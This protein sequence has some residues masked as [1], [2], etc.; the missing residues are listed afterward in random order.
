MSVQ[1]GVY[2]TK[3]EWSWKCPRC[4]T[5]A[6]GPAIPGRDAARQQYKDHRKTCSLA[7]AAPIPESEPPAKPSPKPAEEKQVAKTRKPTKKQ[8][9]KRAK[10]KGR[11]RTKGAVALVFKIADSMSDAPRKDVIAAC[12]K[13]GVN[14]HT[15]RTQY[16]RW[17]HS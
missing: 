17:S 12:V 5:E 2:T 3:G 15:A 13:K 11:N 7:A 10:S 8:A 1:L 4:G 9:R 6:I 16:Q 14:V